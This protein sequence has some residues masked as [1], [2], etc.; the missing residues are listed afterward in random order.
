[1]TTLLCTWL[2]ILIVLL[3]RIHKWSS[4]RYN[5]TL[6]AYLYHFDYY[7]IDYQELNYYLRLCLS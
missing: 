2:W 7:F 1:M 3:I 6:Y 4:C 5:C